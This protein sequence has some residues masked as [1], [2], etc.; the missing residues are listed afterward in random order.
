[1]IACSFEDRHRVRDG[2][3][4][5][6]APTL[7]VTG[8]KA[9]EQL[10]ERCARRHALRSGQLAEVDSLVEGRLRLLKAASLEKRL[11]V[12]RKELE[13]HGS[14]LRHERNRAA[15]QVRGCGDVPAREGTTAGRDEAARCVLA[16]RASVLVER[17]ELR[18]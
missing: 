12:F 4:R 16:D 17:A 13:P 2:L 7:R 11:A 8:A 3:G 6:L 1:M 18:E 14:V 5:L 9:N 10:H 15:E